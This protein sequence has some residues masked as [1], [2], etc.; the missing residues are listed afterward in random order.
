MNETVN[1]RV[2]VGKVGRMDEWASGC[3]NE[4]LDPWV[5]GYM[6]EWVG[7]LMGGWVDSTGWL[8]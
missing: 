5:S 2:V 6:K 1:G 4:W 3:M 7:W 8:V